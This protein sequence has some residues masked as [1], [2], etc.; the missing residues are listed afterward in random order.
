MVPTFLHPWYLLGLPLAATP[1]VLY[2]L[3][4]WRLR[5]V[6]WGAMAFLLASAER[7][8]RRTRLRDIVL[9]VLRT[10]IIIGIVI[11][12]SRPRWHPAFAALG[13][14]ARAI[15]VVIDSSYSM[16]YA[17]E[18]G[19]PLEQAKKQ[20]RALVRSLGVGDRAA[21]ILCC[22]PARA[23][24]PLLTSD[25]QALQASLE[26]VQPTEQGTDVAGALALAV[27]SFAS[28]PNL[29]RE[30]HLFTDLQQYGWRAVAAD[31][32][33][34]G[35]GAGPPPALTIHD[36]S[37]PQPRNARIES[38]RLLERMPGVGYPVW[39]EC[40]VK[41]DAAVAL[42]EAT[43]SLF[44]DG[45]RRDQ[46]TVTVPPGGAARVLLSA[47]FD[48][49]GDHFVRASLGTDPL[50]ADNQRFLSVRPRRSIPVLLVDGGADSAARPVEA[51]YLSVAL[52][53]AP[54][55]AEP[56]SMF[57]PVVV[58]AAE[59]TPRRVRQ[60][61]VIILANVA[62]LDPEATRAL[63]QQVRAGK[64]LMVF[65]GDRVSRPFYNESMYR[66]GRGVLPASIGP[67]IESRNGKPLR[68]SVDQPALEAFESA[69]VLPGAMLVFQH[70][71][72]QMDDGQRA[73]ARV[74]A[75]L[76]DG[77]PLIV[78]KSLGRGRTILVA[79]SAD[80][81]WNNLPKTALFLPMLHEM[82]AYLASGGRD[83]RDGEVGEP[84][85]IA[86]PG[87]LFRQSVTVLP[88]GSTEPLS[89][90]V[91]P[92][93]DRFVATVEQTSRSGVYQVGLPA[94][95]GE[96]ERRYYCLNVDPREGDLAKL[97]A[98]E[99]KALTQAED[100]TVTRSGATEH[101]MAHAAARFE[102]GRLVLLL[103][104][105]LLFAELAATQIR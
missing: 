23:V 86:V 102:A 19:T 12:V 87:D 27:E 20:A 84:L 4:R 72:L 94:S 14:Q 66:Q 2:L 71:R 52:R 8:S 69:A 70:H 100:L 38:L 41:N 57:A 63:E 62:G 56:S 16:T 88:P 97:S 18:G 95:S 9:L 65:L 35:D 68:L 7:S 50:A 85:R 92:Q 58:P 93:G 49:A 59:L 37:V 76:P 1:L 6:E 101:G 29:R 17:A 67:R 40:R 46:K 96:A 73:S 64:G 11:A 99:L 30:I 98:R 45:F 104:C 34:S 10:L 51:A 105:F 103:V 55:L 81:S 78:E 80:G 77:E 43:V 89:V 3:R 33:R 15:A 22:S 83:D 42:D 54:P 53:P 39:I 47:R 75:A 48:E 28:A 25:R 21:L 74:L 36:V 24:I 91:L 90:Q 79:T 5:Q 13:G 44:V 60:A 82:I 26:Q 32:L 31:R 61:D